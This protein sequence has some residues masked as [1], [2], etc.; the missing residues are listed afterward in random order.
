VQKWE[1]FA[2]EKNNKNC[3]KFNKIIKIKIIK[4][5]KT[6]SFPQKRISQI[7]ENLPQKNI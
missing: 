3:I 6:P 4:M 5:K 7:R 2:G 1:T